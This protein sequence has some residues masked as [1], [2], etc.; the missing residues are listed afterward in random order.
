MTMHMPN[1]VA[2]PLPSEVPPIEV[3]SPYSGQLLATVAATDQAN[4]DQ[5]IVDRPF[6]T[7]ETGQPGGQQRTTAGADYLGAGN[8]KG[9]YDLAGYSQDVAMYNQEQAA[10]AQIASDIMGMFSMGGMG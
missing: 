3:R 6:R 10:M 7:V 5:K 9:Q 8:L 2:E 4:A 1:L